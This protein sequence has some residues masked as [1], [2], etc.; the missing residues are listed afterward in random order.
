MGTTAPRIVIVGGGF[1]GLFSARRLQRRLRR[2]ADLLFVTPRN[3]MTYQPFLAEA[4]VGSLEPRH[5]VVPLRRMLPRIEILSA[6]VTRM[7]HQDHT[8]TI[9]PSEGPSYDLSYDHLVVAVGGVTRLPPIPGVDRAAIP[10][11]T[12]EEAIALRNHV[13]SRLDLAETTHD[14]QVRRRALTF[15]VVGGGFTGVEVLGEL[16]DMTRSACR[17]YRHVR[18]ADLHWML[19]EL[20]GRILHEVGEEVGQRAAAELRRRGIDLRLNVGVESAIGGWIHLSDGTEFAAGTLVWTAGVQ[21]HPVLRNSDLPLDDKGRIQVGTDLHVVATQGVWSAGDS[22]AVPDLTNPGATTPP[23]A[24]HAVRQARHLADNLVAVLRGEPVRPYAHRYI[25]SVASLGL[26]KGVAELYGVQLRGAPAWILHRTYHLAQM[27][28]LNRKV[29]I[30]LDWA[31]ASLFHRDPVSF[32]SMPETAQSP[33][34][35]EEG[36][37][38]RATAVAR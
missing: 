17:H 1:V 16:E 9:Q 36:P 23:T 12:V 4:A 11:K 10:F 15:V 20:T 26:Y 37:P 27:P 38:D 25:G 35:P 29:R 18:P 13:L 8:I 24:Q 28:T 30:G 21:P 19:V 22:A 32:G 14:P 31:L 6:R 5:V 33:E 34:G 3:F 2:E 7:C